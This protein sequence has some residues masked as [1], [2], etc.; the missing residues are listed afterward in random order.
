MYLCINTCIVIVGYKLIICT[1]SG[2]VNCDKNHTFLDNSVLS[3]LLMA[4]LSVSL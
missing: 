1:T 3:I 4:S 2:V